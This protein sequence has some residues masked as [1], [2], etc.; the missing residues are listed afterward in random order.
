MTRARYG[1]LTALALAAAG[2]GPQAKAESL[3]DAITMAYQTNPT[4]QN[5]RAQLRITDET[6]VQARAGYRPQ[7][8]AQVTATRQDYS[9]QTTNSG[10]AA[11]V[12]TQ[13]LY[14]GGRTAAAV[15]AAEADILSGR[16]NL[17]LTEGNVLQQVIVAYADVVRDQEGVAIRVENLSLLVDQ[18]REAQARA[19]VG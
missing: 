17:R 11:I 18:L 16:E 15:G 8:N 2:N 12:A 10:S 9:N 3:A 6:Y 19:K 5:E 1:F 7:V 13:P 4:L 14:S